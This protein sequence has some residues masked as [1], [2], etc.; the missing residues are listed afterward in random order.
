MAHYQTIPPCSVS[1]GRNELATESIHDAWLAPS[2]SNADDD[3]V[4]FV[5]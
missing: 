5:G 4:L 3:P 2:F 1:P